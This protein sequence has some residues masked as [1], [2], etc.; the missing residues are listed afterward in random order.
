MALSELQKRSGQAIVQIF[1]TSSVL[2]DCGAVT[3]LPGD[4]GHLTYGKLQATLGSG[5]LYFLIKDY[6]NA[7]GAQLARK[8][9]PFLP[10]LERK[11]TRLDNHQSFKRHL[12]NAGDDPVM[13]E[14]QDAFFDRTFWEPTLASADWIGATTALGH[15]I[16]FDSR[17]HGSWHHV[18]DT[19]IASFGTLATIGETMWMKKYVAHR[20][21][22][23]ATHSNSALHA[24]VYRMD[25]FKQLIDD[26]R[27]DLGL[28]FAVRGL[29]ISTSSLDLAQATAP[30]ASAEPFTGR[31]LKLDDPRLVGEDVREVQKALKEK[32]Y[33]LIADGIFGAGTDVAIRDFQSKNNLRADGVVGALTRERLGLDQ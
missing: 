1:E 20:R 23:L 8:L 14:V 22:W 9:R 4:T 10:R 21:N 2:G 16:I 17:I 29:E 3:V 32:G 15:A 26:N 33:T 18:R 19:G 13:R 12:R 24:T 28:P 5:R 27:W 6:V 11:D 30:R 7:S 25:A 31:L